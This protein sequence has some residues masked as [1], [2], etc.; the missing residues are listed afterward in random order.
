MA[1]LGEL[2]VR[3]NMISVQQLQQAQEDQKRSGGR[4]GSS[5]VKMGMIEETE[6]LNFLSK[7]Y[8]VP[9]INLEEFE[10][11]AEIVKLISE[12]VATK[13]QVMPVHRAG[14]SLVVAMADPSNIFAIDDIKFLTGFN[15][16]VVVASEP[17]IQKAIEKYYKSGGET[18]YDEVMSGFD[19]DEIAFGTDD[20][21]INSLDLEKSAE[22]APVVKLVNLILIDAIKKGASDIHIEPYEKLFR[23][24]YRIDGALYEVMK[25][26]LKLKQAV[27]SRLKIMSALD[28]AE[29]RLPQDGRIKLKLGKGREMDFRVSVLPTL[30]GEKTVLR[31]LD[32]G[33]LQLDMTKLGFEQASLD[34]FKG[35]IHKP[36][37][38][39]LVTGP[40]GSG[41]TTTLYSALSELNQT[42]DN[43]STAEDPVE[44][45]L[46]GINQ[47]QMQE[48]IGLNFAA[49]LR[50]FLRQDPDVIMVGEIRDFETCEIAIKA[51]LTGHLVLSTLHTND[52]PATV[53]RMLNM[54]IEPFLI[55]A[56]LN[57][58]VAQRLL[59][60]I[61][62]EC[63]EPNPETPP[64]QAFRDL[65]MKEEHIGKFQ[66]MRGRGCDICS[67]TGHK[68]RIAIYEVMTATDPLKEAILN[69][70]SAAEL[71][72]AAIR[73]G[74][75]TLRQAALSKLAEGI[76]TMEEIGRVTAAD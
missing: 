28:I 64:P 17:Q 56:A 67:G 70:A 10:I 1:R 6:L 41:K 65:Q 73:G 71:K 42:T 60:K 16:E 14:A 18:S 52:A 50:S 59:R 13:H 4:L 74:M 34:S 23:V 75:K 3:E 39:V 69:G 45:N 68:G 54:G 57:V 48:A 61:C 9:S 30:F 62:A 36:Y 58:I 51:A 63:K 22:E 46:A 31:L 11:D 49:A 29:R 24:R 15:I 8:H 27:I 35:G 40:T 43:I 2:L 55:C 20:D 76:T 44:F 37:G 21:S 5:L 19:E 7:Q 53:S 33:N 12:E 47:V 38:M 72:A 25:P 26:P 32:K 66:L